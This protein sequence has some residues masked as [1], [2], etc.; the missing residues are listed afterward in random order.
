M[1]YRL[2]AIVK[3]AVWYYAEPYEAARNI[4]GHVAFCKFKLFIWAWM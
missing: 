3:D 4:G 2:D 1:L